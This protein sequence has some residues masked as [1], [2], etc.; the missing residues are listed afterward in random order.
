MHLLVVTYPSLKVFDGSIDDSKKVSE[1]IEQITKNTKLKNFDATDRFLIVDRNQLFHR[2]PEDDAVNRYYDG[3]QGEIYRV[4]DGSSTRYRYVIAPIAG[5]K[6]KA[7]PKQKLVTDS[8]YALGYDT[9]LSML[10]DRGCKQSLLDQYSI[11]KIQMKKHFHDA[12]IHNISIPGL[13]DDTLIVNKRGRA[14]YVFFL[15]RDDGIMV[16]RRYAEL[17]SNYLVPW[18]NDIVQHYNS[19]QKSPAD[20]LDSNPVGIPDLLDEGAN[21]LIAKFAE[22]IEVIVVYNNPVGSPEINPGIPYKFIQLFSIQ[23]LS[24]NVTKHV[25]QPCFTLLDSVNDQDEIRD[26]Y[27]INGRTLSPDE[28]L[29]SYNL[30]EGTRLILI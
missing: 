19:L 10:S 20:Q 23:N 26:M 11:P 3:R 30:R 6:D 29:A 9:I 2:T 22:K 21:S 15:K 28:T 14:V 1:I 27:A 5:T 18:V 13:S 12:T 24:F 25:D 8:V 16:S 4:M 17:R 7:K